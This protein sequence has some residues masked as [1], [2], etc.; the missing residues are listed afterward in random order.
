MTDYRTLID[1]DIWTFIDKINACYP[2][3]IGDYAIGHRREV[4]DR[5][6]RALFSGCPKVFLAR[7]RRLMGVS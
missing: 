6:C 3:D 2:A 7:T 1:A 5:M 4:Y